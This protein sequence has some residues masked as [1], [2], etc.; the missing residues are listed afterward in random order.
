M[1]KYEISYINKYK[2]KKLFIKEFKDKK[3]QEEYSSKLI[4]NKNISIK[5]RKIITKQS[6]KSA[7]NLSIIQNKKKIMKDKGYIYALIK[8]DNIVYI[9]K[10]TNI[11][12]RLSSHITEGI[13]DF[14]YYSIV[15]VI[16]LYKHNSSYLSE[17]EIYYIEKIRPFYNIAHNNVKK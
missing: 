14:D 6:N 3:S 2:R 9:G 4:Q 16:D 8:D 5:F 13:K 12:M 11:M 15:E 1:I 7:L 10:S 17:R